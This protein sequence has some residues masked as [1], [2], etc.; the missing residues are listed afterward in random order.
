MTEQ[1][2]IKPRR[3]CLFYGCLTGIVCLL[4]VLIAGLLG[5]H[6][7]KRMLNKYTDNQPVPLPEVSIPRAA[8]DALLCRVE[9]FRDDLRAGRTPPALILSADEVN[10]LIAHD[11]ELKQLRGKLYVQLEGDRL[12]AQVSLPMEDVGLPRFRGR[13]LNGTTSLGIALHNGILYGY[14]QDFVVKGRAVPSAYL[15]VIRRQNLADRANENARASV[16]L[17]LLQSIQVK[18]SQLIVTPKNNQ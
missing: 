2:T 13:Y 15:N 10:A 14:A 16:A 4:A 3:G 12:K 5:I 17:N 9:D 6:E 1:V 11:P 7:F 8:L 18:N